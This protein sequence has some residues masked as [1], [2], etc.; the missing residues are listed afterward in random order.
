M[1]RSFGYVFCLALLVWGIIFTWVLGCAVEAGNPPTQTSASK[2][3]V[4]KFNLY[5][6]DAPIDDAVSLKLKFF[7]LELISRCRETPKPLFHKG[8]GEFS[9]FRLT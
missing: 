8:F 1:K 5:L 7:K 2:A 9:D 6:A 3:K 4:N